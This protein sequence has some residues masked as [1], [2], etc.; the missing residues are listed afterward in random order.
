MLI[1]MKEAQRVDFTTYEEYTSAENK[2]ELVEGTFL[3]FNNERQKMIMLCL[4][5]MGISAFISLLP[6]ESKEELFH[7][8]QQDLKK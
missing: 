5:N 4:Y 1:P 8:I 7:L 6:Q 2:L 3:P